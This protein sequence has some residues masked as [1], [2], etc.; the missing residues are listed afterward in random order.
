MRLKD[1]TYK[2]ARFHISSSAYR[3]ATQM[4]RMERDKLERYIIQ[5]PR[6]RTAMKPLELLNDT[7]R[8]PESALRMLQAARDAGNVGPMAA[9]AGTQAQ[10]AGEAARAAKAHDII[11]E[12]G[13]DM[14]L[15]LEQS[16]YIALYAG[17]E[18]PISDKLALLI[19]PGH[20]LGICSSS[21]NMGHSLSLG[22]CDLATVISPDAALADALATQAC[23]SVRHK[24]DIQPVLEDIA[25][26]PNVHGILIA[27]GDAFGFMGNNMPQLV[28]NGDEQTRRKITIH[29]A[30]Q[31]N[32]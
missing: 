1:F 14:Y 21:S 30:G 17:P 10:L 6:F 23:N 20:P 11:V 24:N 31:L 18:H 7:P 12:N 16:I 26:R 8:P 2:E 15:D 19:Q 9:V 29:R 13:G 27:M 25:A 4:I 5:H 28:R 32:G 22:R 3:T